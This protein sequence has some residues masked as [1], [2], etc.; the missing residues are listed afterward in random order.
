MNQIKD[1]RRNIVIHEDNDESDLPVNGLPELPS[2]G[3]QTSFVPKNMDEPKIYTGDVIVSFTDGKI[4][5][6]ELI[7]DHL[8]EGVLVVSL[9]TG[10]YE[11]I[12]HQKFGSR[13]YQSDETHI[14]DDIV[15]EAEK[16]DTEFD[17]SALERPEPKRAR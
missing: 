2:I 9:D 13:F 12:G 16:W 7:Y 6:A 3:R 14:Y 8:D 10:S 17:P 15:S 11:L 4:D 5:F 1:K